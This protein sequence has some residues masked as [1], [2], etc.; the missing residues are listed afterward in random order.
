M[1]LYIKGEDENGNEIEFYRSHLKQLVVSVM[2][3]H[4]TAYYFMEP[5]EIQALIDYIKITDEQ[6]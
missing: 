2:N 6:L 4:G 3:G 5:E 1:K